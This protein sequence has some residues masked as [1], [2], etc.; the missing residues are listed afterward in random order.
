MVKLLAGRKSL[1]C[2]W[3]FRCKYVSDSE[4]PKYEARLVEKG[5]KQEHGVDYDEIFLLIIEK[6]TIRLLLGVVTTKDLEFEKLDMK[7]TF[8][9]GHLDDLGHL[10]DPTGRFRG[11]SGGI[12]PSMSTEEKPL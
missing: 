1:P 5:F 7:T 3:V 9:H 11:Y 12:S 8:L 10:H 2:K 4:K 6:T